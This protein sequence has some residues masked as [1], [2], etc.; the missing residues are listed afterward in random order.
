[1]IFIQA[2]C[3]YFFDRNLS[4]I[5][6][7]FFLIHF[8]FLSQ[9]FSNCMFTET[10]QNPK[11][12]W[13]ISS[14]HWKKFSF[15]LSVKRSQNVELDL[16]WLKLEYLVFLH[17]LIFNLFQWLWKC[18]VFGLS[19]IKWD[20]IE[21]PPVGKDQYQIFLGV[22]N[23]ISLY[24]Y[25]SMSGRSKSPKIISTEDLAASQLLGAALFGNF[26]LGSGCYEL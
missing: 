17:Y 19:L 15:S 21:V 18:Q 13:T 23:W 1:M 16:L 4:R 2:T 9:F 3:C 8:D 7:E 26:Y 22:S 11:F 25:R 12:N 14:W 20:A 24:P 5:S 6:S 10:F